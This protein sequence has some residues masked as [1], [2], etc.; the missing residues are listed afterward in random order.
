MERKHNKDLSVI[1]KKY[2]KRRKTSGIDSL[3]S[4]KGGY[5]NSG[6]E[7]KNISKT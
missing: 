4:G 7:V 5:N 2:D 6:N 1:A 3:P